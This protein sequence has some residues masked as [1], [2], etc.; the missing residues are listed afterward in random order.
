MSKKVFSN[1]FQA[2]FPFLEPIKTSKTSIPIHPENVRGY[3][4]R[5]F[6]CF[7]GVLKGYFDLK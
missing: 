3:R 1:P 4:N 7:Q 6:R 2:N 5:G